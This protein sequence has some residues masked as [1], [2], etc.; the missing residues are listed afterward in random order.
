LKDQEGIGRI[1]VDNRVVGKL[2][3]L[4]QMPFSVYQEF[5]VG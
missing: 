1:N 4:A 5:D 3:E 2:L